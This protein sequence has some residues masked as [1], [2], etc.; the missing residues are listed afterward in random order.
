[1]KAYTDRCNIKMSI[2]RMLIAFISAVFHKMLTTAVAYALLTQNQDISNFTE[3]FTIQ[4]CPNQRRKLKNKILV[5]LR[6]M[7]S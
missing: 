2:K 4:H 5:H 6:W 7:H 3:I 1:M